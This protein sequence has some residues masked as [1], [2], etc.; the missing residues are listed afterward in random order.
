MPP[1]K[2][3]STPRRS[4]PKA[5]PE[6]ETRINLQGSDNA[7]ATGKSI[8]ANIKIIF[9]GGWKPFAVVLLL[10]AALLSVIL[11]YVVPRKARA[12]SKQFNV[13]VAQFLVQDASGK[14]ISG[15]DGSQLASY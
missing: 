7:V 2:R 1:S 3:K 5:E 9:Q 6:P 10:V 12:M 13:A 4:A 15:K 14:T 11:W 8:A